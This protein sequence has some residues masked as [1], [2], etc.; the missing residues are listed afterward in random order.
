MM[1][2]LMPKMTQLDEDNSINVAAL[3]ETILM[4]SYTLAPTVKGRVVR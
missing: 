1:Y 4:G 2:V 3:I